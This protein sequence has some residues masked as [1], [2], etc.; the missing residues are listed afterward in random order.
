MKYDGLTQAQVDERDAKLKQ[1]EAN[2]E[3]RE[4]LTSTDWYVVRN[5]ETGA[6]IPSEV[7]K[8]RAE[9]RSAVKE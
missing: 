1:E 6:E 7:L 9:A 8:K 5:A 4:Y 3:A 2:R